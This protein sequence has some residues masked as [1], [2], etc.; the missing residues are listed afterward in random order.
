MPKPAA[1]P[2]EKPVTTRII[3]KIGGSFTPSIKDALSGN[4]N[5]PKVEQVE[6]KNIF[7]DY[8]HQTESFTEQQLADAWNRYLETIADRPNLRSTLATVPEIDDTKLYLRVGNSVQEE[9]VRLIKPDLVSWLRN[10]LKNSDIEVITRFE[11]VESE[12]VLF[13]DSEKLKMMIQKNPELL[14]LKQ[15]FN[16]DF[17]E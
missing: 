1:E 15:R 6:Q 3:K 12:R 11:R 2:A 17:K 9:E 13:S 10:E 5:N 14:E 7:A 16:L 4:T 8:Q